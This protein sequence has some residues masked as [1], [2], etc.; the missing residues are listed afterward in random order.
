MRHLRTIRYAAGV[1]VAAFLLML[2]GPA[3]PLT[4]QASPAPLSSSYKLLGNGKLS[5]PSQV[6]VDAHHAW[7]IIQDGQGVLEI[8][9]GTHAYV[10]TFSLTAMGLP[11]AALG[12][13]ADDGTHVW[14][15]SSLGPLAELSASTGAL[16]AVRN[17]SIPSTTP[18]RPV[19]LAV[20]ATHFWVL[21]GTG[22]LRGYDSSTGAQVLKLSV[23]GSGA[24]PGDQ[25]VSNG[26][27]V[28]VMSTTLETVDI[29]TAQVTPGPLLTPAGMGSPAGIGLDGS[30]TSGS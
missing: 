19:A 9:R 21:S 6:V 2:V 5:S 30:G 20:D 7:V 13:I 26:T 10:A 29:A 16:V 4:A 8:D 17:A 25:V 3:V 27:N 18:A 11:N 15:Q 28:F 24:A 14:V 12:A 23:L 22:V 1:V